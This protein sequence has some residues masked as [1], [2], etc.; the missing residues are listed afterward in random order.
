LQHY[1]LGEGVIPRRREF[2]DTAGLLHQEQASTTATLTEWI[3]NFLP[4]PSSHATVTLRIPI[5]RL[6]IYSSRP[7]NHLPFIRA[8][9]LKDNAATVA[10]GFSYFHPFPR[11]SDF[12]RGQ[13]SPAS[14]RLSRSEF[15]RAYINARTRHSLFRLSRGARGG[16]QGDG[17]VNA[18]SFE[19]LGTAICTF[20]RTCLKTT[21]R[22]GER[23]KRT[24]NS[25]HEPSSFFPFF[26]PLFPF[27]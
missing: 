19:N 20:E 23:T 9:A 2:S 14:L 26:F 1:R 7:E 4:A 18:A 22:T 15:L 24:R 25:G 5:T 12:P 11:K 8:S 27:P 10:G 3:S 17:W 6:P 13:V 21:S 16:G